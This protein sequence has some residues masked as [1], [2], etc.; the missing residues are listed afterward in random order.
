MTSPRSQ[1]AKSFVG[2]LDAI[3]QFVLRDDSDDPVRG[4][5]CGLYWLP[6][7]IAV[8]VHA[9]RRLVPRCKSS[10]NGSLHNLGYTMSLGRLECA[11]ILTKIFPFLRDQT[12]ELRKWS[13]RKIEPQ[14]PEIVLPILSVPPQAAVDSNEET[15]EADEYALNWDDSAFDHF[16]TRLD[17]NE[18]R[19][20]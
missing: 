7:G 1:R 17:E 10:I 14:Q 19:F 3:R 18:F 6:D 4:L 12:T 16:F 9:V 13:I 11:E 8:D 20:S 2:A 5:A 15:V